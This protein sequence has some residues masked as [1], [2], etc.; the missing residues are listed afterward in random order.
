MKKC[1]NPQICNQINAITD[2]IWHFEKDRWTTKLAKDEYLSLKKE[3]DGLCEQTSCKC[4]GRYW[5]NKSE[6]SGRIVSH[7]IQLISW[8]L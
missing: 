2:K 5:K 8:N 6:K 3:S 1:T 7:S 4:P